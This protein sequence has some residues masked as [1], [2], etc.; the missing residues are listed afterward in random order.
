MLQKCVITKARTEC[1]CI[2]QCDLKRCMCMKIIN[3]I[4]TLY[5]N[6]YLKGMQIDEIPRHMA[7]C[8]YLRSCNHTLF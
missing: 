8:N 5:D 3:G 2:G 1:N 7:L 6:M 4:I